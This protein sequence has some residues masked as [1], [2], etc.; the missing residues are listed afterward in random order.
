MDI[1]SYQEKTNDLLKTVMADLRSKMDTAYICGALEV[2]DYPND[3][4]KLPKI[5]ITAA[6][7]SVTD[8]HK[9]NNTRNR[10]F[11]ASVNNL[12]HFI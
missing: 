2:S 1:K 8:L 5:V 10:E 9:H 4:Y 3:N 11:I 12:Q 7:Q 6:L